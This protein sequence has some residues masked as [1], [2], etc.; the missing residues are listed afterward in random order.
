MIDFHTHAFPESVAVR[1]IPALEQAGNVQAHTDGSNA[2]LL[3]SMDL[4]GDEDTAI[5]DLSLGGE[6]TIMKVFALR[7]GFS[8][9][10]PEEE[11]RNDVS[12]GMGALFYT[13]QVN[14]AYSSHAELDGTHRFDLKIMF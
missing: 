7:A 1:A 11:S 8:H 14:Y 5:Y 10:F 2:G 12:F 6:Y 13:F 4:A 9:V 3:A